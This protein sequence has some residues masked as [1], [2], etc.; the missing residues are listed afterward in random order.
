MNENKQP[1]LKNETINPEL[2]NAD[3][4]DSTEET[5]SM[6]EFEDQ[7]EQSFHKVNVG[8]MMKGTIVGISDTEVTLDLGSYAEGII[9]ASEFS[10]DPNFSIRTDVVVGEKVTVKVIMEDDGEGNILLSKKQADFVL[11]WKTLNEY[12]QNRTIL[13][14]KVSQAVKGGVITYVEGIRGFIPA[15]QLSINYVEN[16]EDWANKEIEAI[17]ITVEEDKRKLVLSGKEVEQEKV[18]ANK[19]GKL[20]NIQKGMV[21]KGVVEKIMPYGAFIKIDDD[22]SG[23]VHI[24]QISKKFINSPNE[25][26]KVGEEVN[27]K[28]LDVKDGKINLSIKAVE[29]TEKVNKKIENLP[30]E[31]TSNEQATT[32]LGDLLKK[33]KLD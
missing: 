4:T 6:K 22:L 3:I 29:N 11:A 17:V 13:K 5:L 20:S 10:N 2:E 27:V 12:M 32:G 26:I 14:V 16:L 24:S 15:S 23:L 8:D 33:I 1:E 25:A 9:K 19:D 7:I 28:V 18:K 31:F 21:M 30:N